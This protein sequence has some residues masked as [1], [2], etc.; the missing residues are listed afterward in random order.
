[1]HLGAIV[2]NDELFPVDLTMISSTD[3][4]KYRYYRAH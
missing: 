1:M 3:I 4:E 2:S